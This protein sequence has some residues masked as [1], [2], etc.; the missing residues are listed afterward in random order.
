M[1]QKDAV[2][3]SGIDKETPV[4]ELVSDIDKLTGGNGIDKPPEA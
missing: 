3:G 1:M 4:G 2:G